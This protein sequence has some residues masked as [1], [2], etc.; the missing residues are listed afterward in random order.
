ARTTAVRKLVS[1]AHTAGAPAKPTPPGTPPSPPSTVVEE[2]DADDD[3]DAS[4]DAPAA[5]IPRIRSEPAEN[6]TVPMI[7][8]SDGAS[9][10]VLHNPVTEERRRRDGIA[11]ED[12]GGEGEEGEVITFKK[13]KSKA[14]GR[15][16]PPPPIVTPTPVRR[17]ANVVV[18]E[19]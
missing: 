3:G 18:N 11:D 4:D 5:P 7:V 2:G 9:I 16:A 13:Q 8:V 12:V 17:G 1:R 10:R 6:F 19:K 14:P 15:P